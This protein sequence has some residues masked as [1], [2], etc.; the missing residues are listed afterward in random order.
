AL[1]AGSADAAMVSAP[2]NFYAE[3]QG[4]RELALISNVTKDFPFGTTTAN[5]AWVMAHKDLARNFVA[6]YIEAVEWFY[7][8]K[9]RDETIRLGL[10]N[11]KMKEVD[12]A[13]TY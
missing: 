11:T 6:A 2:Y 4:F 8:K 3:A 13:K 1:Q 9:N 12:V 7:D 10:S 5:R